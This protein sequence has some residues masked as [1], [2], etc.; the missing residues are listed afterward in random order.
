MKR[1]LLKI[2]VALGPV[3][4][5]L[6][7]IELH[8]RLTSGP[9]VIEEFI[10]NHEYGWG[11]T[12]G[13]NNGGYVQISEQGLR[14]PP[15]PMPKPPHLTRVLMLGDSVTF[16][17]SAPDERTFVRQL[18]QKLPGTEFINAGVSAWSTEQEIIWLK[19]EGLYYEPDIVVIN[20]Y[21]ND[22]LGFRAP[23]WM[24]CV[25]HNIFINRSAAYNHYYRGLRESVAKTEQEHPQ[26]AK[27]FFD[28]IEAEGW[29]SD[30]EQLAALFASAS[31]EWSGDWEAEK[32]QIIQNGLTEAIQLSQEHDFEL[33]F[34]LFPVN[35][36]VYA[37]E[38]G[39]VDL[40]K[41]NR[42]LNEF[43]RQHDILFVDLLPAFR[44]H[45]QETLFTDH[46]HLTPVGHD[47][48]TE[49]IYQQAGQ[50]ILK[51]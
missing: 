42:E 34:V 12:P 43:A 45:A 35:V 39:E 50:A 22:W 4:L 25:V 17:G 28:Q 33:I 18:E 15:V 20:I 49:V 1:N 14:N 6:S 26:Y 19:S 9:P 11:W 31:V 32:M 36:Q 7:G 37:Q 44:Q 51:P 23:P 46:V 48:A 27:R 10:L 8:A 3:F 2:V 40:E 24:V 47:V 38:P 41:P 29:R 5:L 30:P 13:Y 16:A 21:H